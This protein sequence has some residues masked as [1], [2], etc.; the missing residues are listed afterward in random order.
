MKAQAVGAMNWDCWVDTVAPSELPMRGLAS[1][2]AS[3][4]RWRTMAS[5]PAAPGMVEVEVGYLTGQE[6]GLGEAG[7]VIVGGGK[8]GDIERLRGRCRARQPGRNPKV[9]A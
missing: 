8:A 2:A 1:K 6:F 9:L 7:A 3:S 5:S 4:Q